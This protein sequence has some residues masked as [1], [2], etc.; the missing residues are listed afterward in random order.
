MY[1]TRP[2]SMYRS[3]PDSLSLP[4]PEGPNS[5]YLVLHDEES[6]ETLC[7]G[8]CKDPQVQGLPFPQNKEL[9]LR[10]SK[11]YKECLAFIPVLD[12]PLSA[13]T[14]YV[15]RRDGR[16]RGKVY[17]NSKEEDMADCCCGKAI[18]D[19]KL[20]PLDPSDLYQ[21]IEI[22]P[23][24]N[25][26]YF[27]AKAVASD[28]LPPYG[29]RMKYWRVNME[30]PHCYQL[31]AAPGLDA[32]KRSGLP[33]F[34]FPLSK[35]CSEAMVVGRWYC[36]FL[37][38][39]EGGLELKHQ[40]K[41]CMFYEMRL[42]QRWER[43]FDKYNEGNSNN[44]NAVFVDAFVQREA[45]LV[46]GSEAFY[47]NHDTINVIDDGFMWFKSYDGVGGERSVGLS[48]KIV[49]RMKWEQERVGWVDG[50]GG[51]MRVERVEEFKGNGKWN[52]FACYVLVERFVLKR[53]DGS[54]ALLTYDFKHT[55]QIRGKWE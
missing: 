39:K 21:Q 50:N 23:R 48:L 37:F 36:P 31:G 7:F 54:L 29:L 3:S 33:G 55:H 11:N 35:D 51:K 16:H 52:K 26:G 42:E 10:Y 18:Q 6:D 22:I 13:N 5:G 40:M 47:D 44:A 49:E 24:K 53:M 46:A 2:L 4:T 25:S 1:V 30:T 27:T 19:V 43:I 12:K 20:K 34:D 9:T 32:S 38:I 14:Y 17:T 41:Q 8:C 28:G 45:V 15:I